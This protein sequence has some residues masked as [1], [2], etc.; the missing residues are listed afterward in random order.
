MSSCVHPPGRIDAPVHSEIR[1]TGAKGRVLLGTLLGHR[2]NV[3][4][5]RMAANPNDPVCEDLTQI[6]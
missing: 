2:R 3:A 1:W 6:I 5:W 4:G